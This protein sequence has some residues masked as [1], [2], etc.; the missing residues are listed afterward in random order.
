[1]TYPLD[2]NAIAGDLFAA[3]GREMTDA[4]ASERMPRPSQTAS[5]YTR[6]SNA[7]LHWSGATYAAT[8]SRFS[9]LTQENAGNQA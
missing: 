3:F 7:C 6:R 1:M 5:R 8:G 2:G 9:Q 4:L